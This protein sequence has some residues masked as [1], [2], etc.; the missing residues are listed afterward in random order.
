MPVNMTYKIMYNKLNKNILAVF[1]I[2]KLL[3]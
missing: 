2:L 1:H 3:K